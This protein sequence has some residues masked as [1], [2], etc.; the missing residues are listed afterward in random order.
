MDSDDSIF[1]DLLSM[2]AEEKSAD[3]LIFDF[4]ITEQRA[5][6]IAEGIQRIPVPLDSAEDRADLIERLL[7]FWPLA[8]GGHTDL[9]APWAKAF[10][11]SILEQHSIRFTPNLRVGEDALFNIEFILRAQSCKYIPF[12]AYWH[13]V[14]M[15]CQRR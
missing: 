12:P 14:R 10:R 9:R 1:P 4:S 11:R 3:L 7:R 8:K 15:G 2:I 5:A 13:R 6:E